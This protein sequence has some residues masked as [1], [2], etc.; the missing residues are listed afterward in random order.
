M[1]EGWEGMGGGS[2][3]PTGSGLV[4]S[5][6]SKAQLGW[7]QAPGDFLALGQFTGSVSG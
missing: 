5:L 2:S 4:S 7:T 6:Y 1:P 3:S